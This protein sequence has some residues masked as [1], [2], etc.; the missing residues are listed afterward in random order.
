MRPSPTVLKNKDKSLSEIFLFV[1]LKIIPREI[2]WSYL[3]LKAVFK[4]QILKPK[5]SKFLGMINKL[6]FMK[7]VEIQLMNLW[8]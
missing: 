3:F 1:I 5:I 4:A 8:S 2:F 7:L 6:Y